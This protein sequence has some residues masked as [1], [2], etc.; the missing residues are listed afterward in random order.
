MEDINIRK[1]GV[2]YSPPSILVLYRDNGVYKKRTMPIRNLTETSDCSLLAGRIK[3]RHKKPLENVNSIRLEKLIR[4]AQ[5]SIK[6]ATKS[7]TLQIISKEF[8]IN[9]DEDLN[10]LTDKE[11]QRR[12]L[13]MDLNFEKHNIDKSHPDFVYDK[14]VAFDGEKLDNEWDESDISSAASSALAG[15]GGSSQKISSVPSP[16]KNPIL[17]S[18]DVSFNNDDG[19][20]EEEDEC[21]EVL[22]EVVSA[23]SSSLTPTNSP[24]LKL[25]NLR[26]AQ[27][28]LFGLDSGSDQE[29]NGAQHK[30]LKVEQERERPK[31]KEE[32][33]PKSME[34]RSISAG[35]LSTN[36]EDDFW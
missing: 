6:G 36:E 35:E 5:E 29:D 26:F 7:E 4:L 9:P 8:E 31:E 12:K 11:L 2:L 32:D 24:Q 14:E 17:R 10:K 16:N 3:S 20:N 19:K 30:E 21:N 27:K 25:K 33:A 28:D 1:I 34:P 15:V 18:K 23:D 13:I 22:E